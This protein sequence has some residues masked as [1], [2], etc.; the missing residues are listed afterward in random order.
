[1]DMHRKL[2][3]ARDDLDRF[4]VMPLSREEAEL[5]ASRG[6]TREVGGQIGINDASVAATDLKYGLT[7]VVTRNKAH[8]ERVPKLKVEGY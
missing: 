3:A 8:F 1:M 2:A 6:R 5:T 7:V 4:E